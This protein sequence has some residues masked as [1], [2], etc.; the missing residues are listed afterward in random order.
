MNSVPHI[1]KKHT[2]EIITYLRLRFH[3]KNIQ[4]RFICPTSQSRLIREDTQIHLSETKTY[5]FHQI[6]SQ[7]CI[8]TTYNAVC[9]ETG[10]DLKSKNHLLGAN[11][12]LHGGLLNKILFK[13]G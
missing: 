8:A 6:H 11:M 7:T 2:L 1:A 13:I 10:V 12:C 4:S 3:Q 5:K 9:I